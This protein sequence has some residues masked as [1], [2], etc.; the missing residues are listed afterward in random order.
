MRRELPN[1][2]WLRVFGATASSESFALA[3]V[4]LSV[5][6]GAVSQRIKALEQFLDVPLFSRQAQGVR[7]TETGRRYA[8]RVLPLLDQLTAAT[9]EA[10]AAD[11]V[12]PVRIT[13][14][15]A[16]AQLWL[17]PRMEDFHRR[18]ESASVEIWADP[19]IVD[20]RTANFDLALRYGKAPF[21]GCD[22]CPLLFDELVPVASPELAGSAEREASGLPT[23]VPLMLDTYW[24]ADFDRW[25]EG[26]GERRPAKLVVQT[27]SLYSMVVEAVLAGRG[28]M[29]G[30]TALLGDLI[31]SGRLR[32]LSPKR[33]VAAN[34]F[35]LLTNASVPPGKSAQIFIDWL[36]ERQDGD[37]A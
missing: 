27:F 25:L 32:A 12:K 21:P 22:H 17:G 2:D 28:F 23:G 11:A 20:L 16:L 10:T 35:H 4:E 1:L 9:R 29:I 33:T 15:P 8:Q 31:A 6:P 24:T 19:T 3:A 5:T 18:H 34:Q 36:L 13:V 37:P 26:A 30:H 7:L 14:L